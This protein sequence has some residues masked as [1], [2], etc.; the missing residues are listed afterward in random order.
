MG[1]MYF[2]L[3]GLGM[4]LESFLL[5]DMI[6]T[7]SFDGN[8]H[9]K[10]AQVKKPSIQGSI[11]LCR[12]GTIGFYRIILKSLAFIQFPWDFCPVK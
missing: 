11:D 1:K 6:P 9:D 3:V 5:L 2:P 10:S 12:H 4:F 7:N 8:G